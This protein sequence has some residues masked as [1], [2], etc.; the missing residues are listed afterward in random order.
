MALDHLENDLK[1]GGLF[2]KA[3]RA[4]GIFFICGSRND[5]NGNW[6]KNHEN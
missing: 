3:N 5:E 6:G 2:N 4:V 1:I